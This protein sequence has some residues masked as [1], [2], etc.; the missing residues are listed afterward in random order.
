MPGKNDLEQ[1]GYSTVFKEVARCVK[2]GVKSCDLAQAASGSCR[3]LDTQRGNG[4]VHMKSV[5]W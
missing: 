2:A 4:G 3:D 5:R 1:G